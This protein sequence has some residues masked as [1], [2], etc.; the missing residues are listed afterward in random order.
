MDD[1]IRREKKAEN[2]KLGKLIKEITKDRR[3]V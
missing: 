1:R 3:K 2:K